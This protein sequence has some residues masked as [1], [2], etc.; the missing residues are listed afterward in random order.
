MRKDNIEIKKINE[1]THY[2]NIN[3]FLEK[4]REA[5]LDLYD[6]LDEDDNLIIDIRN[7]GVG[8]DMYWMRNIVLPNID[9]EYSYNYYVLFNNTDL[10]RDSIDGEYKTGTSM[11]Q[12]LPKFNADEFNE[13]VLVGENQIFIA[14][15]ETS[16]PFGGNIYILVGENVYS[17]ADG[18]ARF[19]K[20][21]GF[22]TTVGHIT[23][24]DGGG[25]A[26]PIYFSLPN[27]GLIL[28]FRISYT[29][30]EDGSSNVEF[31]TTPEYLIDD[32]VDAYDFTM[33]LIRK[34]SK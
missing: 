34:N 2:V 10:I 27:S 17:A 26:N 29:L 23:K 30:N 31:G 13:D 25:G 33:D 12:G 24:G 5:L 16:K 3:S 11:L 19:S 8:S 18:F 14:P 28:G 20:L 1:N 7:N 15:D 21:S 9:R 32:D 22:G 4:D 6:K